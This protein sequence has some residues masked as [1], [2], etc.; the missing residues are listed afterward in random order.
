MANNNGNNCQNQK[1]NKGK[2]KGKNK[3]KNKQGGGIKIE[4]LKFSIGQNQIKNYKKLV[5][6]LAKKS[7]TNMAHQ[8]HTY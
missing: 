8:W 6:H 3:D 2:R 1:G 4:V 7:K 5:K